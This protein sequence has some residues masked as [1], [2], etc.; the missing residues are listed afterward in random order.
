MSEGTPVAQD[1]VHLLSEIDKENS[2]R[3]SRVWAKQV[4]GILD[5]VQQYCSIV[6][7]FI[8]A[9]PAITSLVWGSV[10]LVILVIS[11]NSLIRVG[12]H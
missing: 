10:K 8:Q 9:N 2:A 12:I 6:D 3:R 5:S 4:R 1:V 7:T 11:Y